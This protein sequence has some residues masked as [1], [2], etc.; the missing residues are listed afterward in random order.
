MNLNCYNIDKFKDFV[1]KS[2]FLERYD[3]PEDRIQQI[4]A[5][6][7]KLLEFGFEWLKATFFQAGEDTFKVKNKK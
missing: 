7:I 1:F 3:L 4:K 2:T 5:D 6:D